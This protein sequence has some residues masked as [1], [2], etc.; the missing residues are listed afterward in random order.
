ME[1]KSRRPSSMSLTTQPY[2]SIRLMRCTTSAL[3]SVKRRAGRRPGTLRVVRRAGSLSSNR[4]AKSRRFSHS[5][6]TSGVR[7]GMRALARSGEKTCIVR[8]LVIVTGLSGAGK[9]QAMK[10]FEDFGFACLDTVPPVLAPAF[11]DLVRASD[12]DTAALAFDVR[13]GGAFGEATSTL[14]HFL[15]DVL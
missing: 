8:R 13:S 7:T 15:N 11:V 14:E 2:A 4:M 9:S 12:R 6:S 1:G 3:R 10:S 5:C